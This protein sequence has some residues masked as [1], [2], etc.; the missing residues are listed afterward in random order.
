MSSLWLLAVPAGWELPFAAMAL[1]GFFMSLVNAPTQ[2]LVMLRIPRDLRTQ[3]I[4]A[5]G[6]FQC[7]G[8]PLGLIAAGVALAHYDPRAVLAVVLAVDTLA[9]LTF[10]VTALAE[11]T[12]LR[13]VDS[14]A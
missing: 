1:A 3:G 5:F 8:A 7:I 11:R 6:V 4:A 2:A 9:V 10:V 14:L 12:A 13:S